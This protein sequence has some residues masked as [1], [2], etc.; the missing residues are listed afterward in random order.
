MRPTSITNKSKQS[1]SKTQNSKDISKY[2]NKKLEEI[3]T[4]EYNM[5]C[6]LLTEVDKRLA[7]EQNLKEIVGKGDKSLY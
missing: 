6:E 2:M 7:I 4:L 1:G 5:N 3:S